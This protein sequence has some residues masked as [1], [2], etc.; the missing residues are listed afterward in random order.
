[1][2]ASARPGERAT[3]FAVAC[4]LLSCFVRQNGNAIAELGLRIQGEQRNPAPSAAKSALLRSG[5]FW[6]TGCG[7]R[8]RNLGF[9]FDSCWGRAVRSGRGLGLFGL[10][11]TFSGFE[12]RTPFSGFE[13]QTTLATINLLLGA[14]AEEAERRKETMELFPQSTGFGVKDAAAPRC[15]LLQYCYRCFTSCKSFSILVC[16][17]VVR[18]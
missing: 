9:S 16:A 15:V 8:F 12:F 13:Q 4:S 11:T 7:G 5:S 3:S 18:Y 6:S 10:E 2:A 1:M 14:E 17:T